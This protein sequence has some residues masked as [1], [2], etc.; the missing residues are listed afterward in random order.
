MKKRFVS[1][2]LIVGLLIPSFGWAEAVP[3]ADIN[4]LN[5]TFE[6][7]KEKYPFELDEDKIVK[8]GV[9]GMLQALD[10]NSNYYTKEEAEALLTMTKGEIVGVGVVIELTN[11]YIRIR[12]VIE[13]H[14]A[15]KAGIKEGDILVSIDD[16]S[17]IG[18]TLEE[19]SSMIK[20]KPNTEVKLRVNRQGKEMDFTLKRES[21]EINPVKS[22]VLDGKTGY[23]KID[24]FSHNMSKSVKKS[25]NNFD[26][27][28]IKKVIVDLRNNPGG[29]L[30]EAVKLSNMFVPEGDIVHVRYK[31]YTETIKSTNKNPK[32]EVVVLVNEYSASASEIFAGAI[33]D[34][35]VGKIVGKSSYGKATVQSLLPITDGSLVKLTIAEYLTP[36]K[37]SINKIGVKPDYE[38]ENKND[39]LEDLQLK[40]AVEL[41]SK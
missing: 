14:P 18:M 1:M 19:V 29:L 32:Y 20:G 25:L 40:K 12:E 2:V 17:I 31:D 37:K 8:G 22:K 6:M 34:R 30:T 39:S 26:N 13:E 36:S 23:I 4:F 28:G 21:I 11:G 10:P 5:S 24:E 16:L 15:K 3:K 33:K 38:I 9:K 41:L 27:K 35:K 7:I